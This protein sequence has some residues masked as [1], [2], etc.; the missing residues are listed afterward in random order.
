[1]RIK[2]TF[3]I[4]PSNWK[5]NTFTDSFSN[6]T[7]EFA[8]HFPNPAPGFSTGAQ[9]GLIRK[10]D[11][12]SPAHRESS[13][14]VASTGKFIWQWKSLFPLRWDFGA[15]RFGLSCHDFLGTGFDSAH[16]PQTSGFFMR[17]VSVLNFCVLV[18]ASVGLKDWTAAIRST[19]VHRNVCPH[20][21]QTHRMSRMGYFTP[22]VTINTR[23]SLRCNPIT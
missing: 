13:R 5:S 8:A 4:F 2:A 9:P 6:F 10:H 12:L 11:H 1:M 20:F 23:V 3:G 22:A 15:H 7:N 16:P 19:C 21:L 14:R 18:M 17:S